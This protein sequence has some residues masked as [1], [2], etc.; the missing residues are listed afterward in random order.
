MG[1]CAQLPWGGTARIDRA[2]RWRRV[3]IQVLKKQKT[4]SL[5]IWPMAHGRHPPQRPRTV[6]LCPANSSQTSNSL[7]LPGRLRGCSSCRLGTVSRSGR[8]CVK[9]AALLIS[10][11]LVPSSLTVGG[12]LRPLNRTVCRSLLTSVLRQFCTLLRP[13]FTARLPMGKA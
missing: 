13:G 8:F 7:L 1:S 9:V 2:T 6:A 10:V 11:E 3:R 12:G 4:I 5:S